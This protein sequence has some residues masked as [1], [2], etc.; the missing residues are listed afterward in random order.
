MRYEYP[1]D[2]IREK[3]GRVSVVFDGLPGSTWGANK[4]EALARAKNA[5]AT[6]LS[7]YVDE[8]HP[9]PTPKPA[10]GRPVVALGA[11][12]AG[13][14]ALYNAMLSTGISNV[15]L[16][17]RIGTDEKSVRRLHDPLHR[18]HIGQ[19]ETALAALGLR[20]SVESHKAA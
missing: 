14:L 15:E 10:R 6:V 4:T 17:R 12:E 1:V 19:V 18:S 2:L 7:G 5:L 13:K 16:A 9:V 20:L 8:N 11:L 3:D